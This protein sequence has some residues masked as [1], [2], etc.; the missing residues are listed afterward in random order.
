[1]KY[2]DHYPA[3]DETRSIMRDAYEQTRIAYESVFGKADVGFWP[4]APRT[5]GDSHS[6]FIPVGEGKECMK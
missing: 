5:C 6:G 2:R 4:D 3:N 1:M